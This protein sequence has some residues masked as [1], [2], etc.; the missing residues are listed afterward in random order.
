MR[1]KLFSEEL[2]PK[3]PPLGSQEGSFCY[4]LRI[5]ATTLESVAL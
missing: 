4:F 5:V 2:L 1:A 3:L